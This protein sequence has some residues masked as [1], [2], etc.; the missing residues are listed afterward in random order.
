[1]T[2]QEIIN[3]I[4]KLP[5]TERREILDSL[6]EELAEN[7]AED[8]RVQTALFEAGLLRDARTDVG[9]SATVPPHLAFAR[10]HATVVVDRALDAERRGMIV[11][12]V[13]LLFHRCCDLH[14]PLH[15]QRQDRNQSL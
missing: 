11:D 14:R 8:L 2:P 12:N 13:E 9:E 15:E 5:P 1:M 4:H 6:S 10:R 7:Q 3:E